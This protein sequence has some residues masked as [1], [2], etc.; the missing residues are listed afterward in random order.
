VVIFCRCVATI[1]NANGT[2]AVLA[3][4]MK[5]PVPKEGLGAPVTRFSI[6]LQN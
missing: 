3:P 5:D 6:G 2:K 1:F 4:R